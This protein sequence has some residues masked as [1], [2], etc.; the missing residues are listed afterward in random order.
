MFVNQR[1]GDLQSGELHFQSNIFIV[2]LNSEVVLVGAISD[3][4]VLKFVVGFE[5]GFGLVNLEV[6]PYWIWLGFQI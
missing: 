4:S 2:V 1:V 5:S 3:K 6:Q